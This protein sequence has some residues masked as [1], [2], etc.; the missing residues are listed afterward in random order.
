MVPPDES[1]LEDP[2]CS[3]AAPSEDGVAEALVLEDCDDDDVGVVGVGTGA[4]EVMVTIVG[5]N[6]DPSEVGV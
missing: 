3:P 5:G 4:V 2:D 1:L 6:V